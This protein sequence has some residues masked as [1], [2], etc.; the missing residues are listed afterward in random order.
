MLMHQQNTLLYSTVIVIVTAAVVLRAGITQDI[1]GNLAYG[2]PQ[3]PVQLRIWDWW[4]P[5]TNEEYG[6]YFDAVE[7][8]FEDRYPNIDI[9]Y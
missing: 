6:N 9:V 1:L 4:S 8:L 2:G 5:A 7:K 3:R